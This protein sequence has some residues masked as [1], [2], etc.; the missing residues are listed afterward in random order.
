MSYIELIHA[1]SVDQKVDDVVDAANRNL[2]PG[3]GIC[4]AIFFSIMVK[5]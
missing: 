4:G 5:N 1:S 2:W 3:G